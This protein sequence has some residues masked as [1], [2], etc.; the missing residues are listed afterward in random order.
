M[1]YILSPL[2]L[3]LI[4]SRISLTDAT[5]CIIQ[6]HTSTPLHIFNHFKSITFYLTLT[7]LIFISSLLFYE[8]IQMSLLNRILKFIFQS[9]KFFFFKSNLHLMFL[10]L[11]YC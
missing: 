2:L 3:R 10:F 8:D 5:N 4:P 7:T 9:L 6:I 11:C 1:S